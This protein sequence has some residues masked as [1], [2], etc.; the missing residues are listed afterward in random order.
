MSAIKNFIREWKVK[1]PKDRAFMALGAL[2]LAAA[3]VGVFIPIIPQVPFAVI[4]AFFFSKGS[5][6]IHQWIRHNRFFGKPVRDWEDHRVIRPKLKVFST[7]AM[8]GGAAIAFWK[9]EQNWAI[10]IS[11]VFG[12]SILFVLTRKSKPYPHLPI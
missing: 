4:A 10:G 1:K 7:L 8:A 12:L 2:F 6:R 3:I 5:M 11:I 9:L